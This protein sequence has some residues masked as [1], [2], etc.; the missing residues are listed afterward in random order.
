MSL[1]SGTWVYLKDLVVRMTR[2][3]HEIDLGVCTCG[4]IIE[5][6]RSQRLEINM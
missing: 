2:E 6:E 4:R 5:W 1:F 3:L